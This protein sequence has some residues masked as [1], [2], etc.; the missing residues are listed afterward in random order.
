M[1]AQPVSRPASPCRRVINDGP[2]ERR[3]DIVALE[4][5]FKIRGVH[6]QRE[7][8]H[9][10]C[11]DIPTLLEFSER[12]CIDGLSNRASFSKKSRKQY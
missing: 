10:V 6:A 12:R 4:N 7:P 2:V 9:D 5:D 8:L 3:I 11:R 1:D